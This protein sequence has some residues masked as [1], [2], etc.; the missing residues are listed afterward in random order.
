MKNWLI[1]IISRCI[2]LDILIRLLAEKQRTPR[3]KAEFQGFDIIFAENENIKF[4]WSL[5]IT[6]NDKYLGYF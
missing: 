5:E 4:S 1:K 2:S 3:E 6:R